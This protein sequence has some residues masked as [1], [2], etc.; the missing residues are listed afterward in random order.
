MSLCEGLGLFVYISGKDVNA[1]IAWSFLRRTCSFFF[2]GGVKVM[3]LTVC[4]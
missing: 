1:V 4:M 2:I 3:W